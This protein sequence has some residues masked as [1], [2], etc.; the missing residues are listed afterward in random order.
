MI[1]VA[2]V[3]SRGRMGATVCQAVEAATDMSLVAT[4]DVGDNLADV[5]RADVVVDFATP[6]DAMDRIDR[7]IAAG[8]HAVIGTTGFNEDQL[9]TVGQAVAAQPNLGVIIAPNFSLGAVLLMRFAREAAPFF[10]S[11]EIIELHH[12]EK[13]D[14]PSGTARLT[15]HMMTDARRAAN[16]TPGPDSTDETDRKARGVRVGDI[17][18][19]SV[20]L[21]GL[22]AHQEVLFGSAGDVFTLRHDSFDRESYMPGVLLAVRT[23]PTR[24]GLTVGLEA[25]LDR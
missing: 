24:P 6:D 7:Y 14:T 3:G 10:E 11:A 2:V 20:R 16:V 13:L 4:M 12:P 21:R 5:A 1:N 8:V 15:A 19:H 23:A 25:L 9:L 22:I 18:V 17:P